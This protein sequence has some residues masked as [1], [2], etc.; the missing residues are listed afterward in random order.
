MA[1]NLS[2]VGGVAAQFF[3]NSGAVLT[4]GKLYTYAAG[5]TTPAATYTN[6]SGSTAQPNPIVLD[7][8][9]RVPNSGEIWLTDGINY[10][11]VLKDANDVLIATYDNVS[12]INS[13]F[14]AFTNSQEIFTATSG[15]TVFTL[16]NA[17]QPGTNSLSVFVD[18]VNQYGP[19]AQYAYV[20]TDST[21]VTFNVGLHVG[22]EVKF[23]TTQQQGAGAV[24]ASQVTYDP[25]F[26]GSVVTNVEA[27][28]AQTVSVK[29][30]GAVGDGVT[31]DTAALQTAVNQSSGKTLFLPS[32]TYV[33][34][35]T[36]KL[37]KNISLTGEGSEAS[38]I[39]AT[40]AGVAVQVHEP[41]PALGDAYNKNFENFGI[42]TNVN[43]TFGFWIMRSIYCNY[44]NIQV[45]CP[46]T[47]G[48]SYA[49][50]RVSG[51]VYLNTFQGCISDT[52]QQGSTKHLGRAWWIGG[53]ENEVGSAFAA[54][55]EN[56]FLTCRGIRADI[57]F[58]LDGA[59]GCS[60]TACGG[61]SCTT[62]GFSIRGKYNTLDTPWIE[63]AA[64]KFN[65]YTPPNGSGGFLAPVKAAFNTIVIGRPIGN[66]TISNALNTVLIGGRMT[67]LTIDATSANTA[68]QWCEIQ[69]SITDN[70]TYSHLVYL[71]G[72]VIYRKIKYNVT[73]I[74]N[75]IVNNS[76]YTLNLVAS[77][78]IKSFA[79]GP[80]ELSS[81][82]GLLFS[83]ANTAL[84]V[85]KVSSAPGAPSAGRGV[86]YFDESGG[87]IRLMVRFP[88]GAAQQV[89]IEP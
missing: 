51:A 33:I 16:A 46:N 88:T 74:V 6:S 2:P 32:G 72:G 45:L 64:L 63:D 49:G 28:L 81:A 53:G 40:H 57:G 38:I 17:Y 85:E 8:A 10:K 37:G 65:E 56:T 59:N 77:Q 25:P 41:L 44:K 31:D 58:D 86:L 84:T 19:G 69:T 80:L 15:Q 9:G 23:T 29:D 27:K 73:Q 79:F 66:V 68:L 70:G 87:K 52:I 42:T 76:T 75:E 22:A 35:A 26:T 62:A 50:F 34:S 4:G 39:K 61:E 60:M 67:A 89:A 47:V 13:N 82:G 7:A 71:F 24:D 18:G 14:I 5:T 48:A 54:T 1:V 43:T 78:Y 3:T 11:F 30:F 83:G 55:N 21:T 36:L 20:E 12:G